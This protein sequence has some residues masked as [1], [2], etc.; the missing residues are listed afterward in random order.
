MGSSLFILFYF[1]ATPPALSVVCVCV[2]VC[3]PIESHFNGRRFSRQFSLCCSWGQFLGAASSL[4][5]FITPNEWKLRLD[6]TLSAVVVVVAD[7]IIAVVAVALLFFQRESHKIIS[8]VKI[9]HSIFLQRICCC[10]FLILFRFA[11]FHFVILITF[12][13]QSFNVAYLDF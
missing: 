13:K 4:N 3:F 12:Y 1:F 9:F 10:Y 11:E 7:A 6:W 8:L 2:C 5:V